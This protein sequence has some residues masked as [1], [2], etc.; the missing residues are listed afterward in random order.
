[1]HNIHLHNTDDV[2][3]TVCAE[4]AGCSGVVTPSHTFLQ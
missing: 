2:G 3:Q 4:L 1:M